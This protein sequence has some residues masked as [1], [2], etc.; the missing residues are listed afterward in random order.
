MK[1]KVIKKYRKDKVSRLER[2]TNESKNIERKV[3]SNILSWVEEMRVKKEFEF[4][5]ARLM[6]GNL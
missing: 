2:D 3:S 6:L 4:L 5:N 1:V